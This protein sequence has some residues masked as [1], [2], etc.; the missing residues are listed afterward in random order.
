M[1]NPKK[2]LAE[3]E[4]RLAKRFP[5]LAA[6]PVGQRTE[7]ATQ[8][9]T[10]PAVWGTALV[11]LAVLIPCLVWGML[12]LKA[13]AAPGASIAPWTGVLGALCLVI[14]LVVVRHMQG[15]VIKR[16]VAQR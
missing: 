5:E 13:H 7:I 1:M 8:A 15:R 3:G 11:V 2:D 4:A 9:S 12:Y 16:L 6:I 10:N 14:L